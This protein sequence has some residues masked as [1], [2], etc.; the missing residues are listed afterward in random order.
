MGQRGFSYLFMLFLVA[1]LSVGLLA[2]R[3]VDK[4]TLRRS[5]ERELLF[6]GRQF[7]NALASYSQIAGGN[8]FN[9]YPASLDE[10]VEDKRFPTMKRHLRKIYADPITGKTDWGL[11]KSGDRIVGVYSLADGVPLKQG[12][13]ENDQANFAGAARY[14]DWIFSWPAQGTTTR[15]VTEAGIPKP[16]R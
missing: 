5:Q 10:L 3:D 16:G 15:P 6:I 1:L 14:S 12:G 2:G 4:T 9:N 13:F 8:G 11:I 7:Q